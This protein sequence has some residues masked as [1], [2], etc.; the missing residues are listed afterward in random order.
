M[1]RTTLRIAGIDRAIQAMSLS[2]LEF[3][4]L[5]DMSPRIG[6]LEMQK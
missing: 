5:P 6:N 4:F 3:L 1:R 2:D